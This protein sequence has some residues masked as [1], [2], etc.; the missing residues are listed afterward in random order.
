MSFLEENL[1]ELNE[2]F[3]EDFRGF[4]TALVEQNRDVFRELRELL[5]AIPSFCYL[6]IMLPS[7]NRENNLNIAITGLTITLSFF[8]DNKSIVFQMQA[9]L[10]EAFF[11]KFQKNWGDSSVNLDSAVESFEKAITIFPEEN[12]LDE[13]ILAELQDKL[14][15]AYFKRSQ[16]KGNPNDLEKAIK[17]YE[18]ALNRHLQ[19]RK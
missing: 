5:I 7:G 18:S 16:I 13:E 6:I 11:E 10:G 4:C 12:A 1:E 8:K 15:L 14:G 2:Q 3:I 19:N 17:A 9:I